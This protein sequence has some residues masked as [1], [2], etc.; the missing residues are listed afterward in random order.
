MPL[1]FKHSAGGYGTLDTLAQDKKRSGGSIS[2]HNAIEFCG[3]MLMQVSGCSHGPLLLSSATLVQ[4]RPTSRLRL[5]Q[6]RL[7]GRGHARI[8]K[9]V[10]PVRGKAGAGVGL[11]VSGLQQFIDQAIALAPARVHTYADC[12]STHLHVFGGLPYDLPSHVLQHP[13][14]FVAHLPNIV[15]HQ[16]CRAPS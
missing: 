11:E 5:R 3:W 6:R 2:L 4:S 7:V 9:S 16:G 12:C 15:R 10:Q 1:A 14:G 8:S 13:Q